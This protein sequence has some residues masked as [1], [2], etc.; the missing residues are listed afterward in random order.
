MSDDTLKSLQRRAVRKRRFPPGARCHRCGESNLNALIETSNPIICTACSKEQKGVTPVEGHHVAG[1]ANDPTFIVQANANV[2]RTISDMQGDWP[3]D[4]L[5]N[6][7]GNL[8][9]KLEAGLRG[10]ADLLTVAIDWLTCSRDWLRRE[11]AQIH[12]LVAWLNERIG[13]NWWQEY[14]VWRAAGG[15]A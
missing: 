11:A 12:V 10:I 13:P 1:R 4:A 5:R 9:T 2:H 6:R 7:N 8:L 3:E 14:L 15:G